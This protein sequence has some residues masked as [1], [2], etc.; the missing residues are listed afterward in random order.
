MQNWGVCVKGESVG[1]NMQDY[2]GKLVE[3]VEVE[4]PGWPMKRTVLFRCDWFD[5][6]VPVGKRVH[7]D[8]N[9]VEVNHRRRLQKY[10]PFILA[11]QAQQV[12]YCGYPSLRN[13]KRDWWAVS[14]IVPRST[15]IIDESSS[16]QSVECPAFQEEEMEMHAIE[17]DTRA[18][19]TSLRDPNGDVQEIADANVGFSSDGNETESQSDTASDVEPTFHETNDTD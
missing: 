4:Y 19:E 2:Y 10:D 8:Y 9:L 13:D 6:T 15:I 1:A 16:S 17:D 11:S 12:F 3:V 5:P 7:N 14:K 18:P